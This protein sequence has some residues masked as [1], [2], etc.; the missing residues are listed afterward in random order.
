MK[1]AAI[2]IGE[3]PE[4]RLPVLVAYD[5]LFTSHQK[6]RV[7]FV[8][9]ADRLKAFLGDPETPYTALDPKHP[10]TF[11]TYMNDPDLINNKV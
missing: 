8:D 11:G 2:R 1:L 10:V 9:D 7:Q 5:G 6:R 4:I 3:H